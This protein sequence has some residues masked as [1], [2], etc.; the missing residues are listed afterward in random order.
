LQSNQI[1]IKTNCRFLFA[2]KNQ[3]TPVFTEKRIIA[4]VFGLNPR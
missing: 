1:L 2:K 3:G 4:D